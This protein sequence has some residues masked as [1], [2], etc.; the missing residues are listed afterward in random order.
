MASP[1]V[2][3]L[4]TFYHPLVGGVETHARAFA[5][6]LRSRRIDV[7]VVTKRIDGLPAREAVDGVPVH[8][9][10][11]SGRRGPL[12]KWAMLP[13]AAVALFRRRREYDVIY[14]PDPRGLGMVAVLMGR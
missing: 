9:I 3:I 1:G 11:L 4:T 6:Y 10:G 12:A 2:L 8:R 7:A 5:S 13:Y 14:C